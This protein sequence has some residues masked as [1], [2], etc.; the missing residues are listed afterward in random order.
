MAHLYLSIGQ[1]CLVCFDGSD[2]SFSSFSEGEKRLLT[3]I[4]DTRMLTPSSDRI[5][6]VVGC[7]SLVMGY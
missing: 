3:G 4:I 2:Y 6:F 7:S 5:I 1:I